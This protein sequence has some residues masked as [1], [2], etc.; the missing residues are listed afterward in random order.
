MN[1]PLRIADREFGSRLILGTG[2]FVNHDVLAQ[3]LN[4]SAT[5]LLLTPECSSA[6]TERSTFW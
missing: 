6:A 3:A 4:A 2:G 1:R 5:E